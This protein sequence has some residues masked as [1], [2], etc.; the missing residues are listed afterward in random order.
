LLVS[1]KDKINLEALQKYGKV[2]QLTLKEI[3][4]Y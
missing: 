1:S 3:F 4:G 2:K